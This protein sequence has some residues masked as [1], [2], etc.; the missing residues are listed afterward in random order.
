MEEIKEESGSTSFS[1]NLN[2]TNKSNSKKDL[3]NINFLIKNQYNSKKFSWEKE[4]AMVI[5]YIYPNRF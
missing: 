4:G 3:L 5:Y 2:S 1:S